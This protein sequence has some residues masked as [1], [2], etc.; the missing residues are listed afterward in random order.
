MQVSSKLRRSKTAYH[1][2]CPACDEM[3]PLPDDWEFDGDLERPT[4]KPSFR[5]TWG[6]RESTLRTCH[7]VVTAGRVAYCDDSTHGLAGQT[8]DMPELPEAY[9]DD[10][11]EEG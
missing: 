6:V 1:W 9:R 2:H 5:H 7:Y 8:I 10:P 4:F 3:H 11:P